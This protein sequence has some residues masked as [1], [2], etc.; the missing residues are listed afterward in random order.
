[1]PW[2]LLRNYLESC[3]N[4]VQAVVSARPLAPSS[5]RPP[6]CWQMCSLR[7][8]S[9]TTLAHE[10]AVAAIVLHKHHLII[11]VG[12]GLIQFVYGLHSHMAADLTL[13]KNL[14][15]QPFS[16]CF[17]LRL[18]GRE[19]MTQKGLLLEEEVQFYWQT[20][21]SS[22]AHSLARALSLFLTHLLMFVDHSNS[23]SD[24]LTLRVF[25]LAV[26]LSQMFSMGWLRLVGSLKR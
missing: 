11:R 24:S 6:S 15:L 9:K 20:L 13:N 21:S 22:R 26:P 19:L 4:I 7:N 25:S 17:L 23:I 8:S 12:A 14:F 1:L 5:S 16:R 18:G 3:A 2:K 10:A